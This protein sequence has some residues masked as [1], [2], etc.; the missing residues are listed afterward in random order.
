[1]ILTKIQY[2][3]KNKA[4]LETDEGYSV[5][6]EQATVLEYSLHEGDELTEDELTVIIRHDMEERAKALALNY[7]SY[8]LRSEKEVSDYLRGKDFDSEI[9]SA[10]IVR[11]RELGYLND[12]EFAEAFVKDRLKLSKHGKS[13]IAFELKLKGIDPL[14]IQ[15]ALRGIGSSELRNAVQLIRKKA[16]DL[17]DFKEQRRITGMLARK[18]YSY[19]MISRAISLAETEPDDE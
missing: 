19:E 11:F 1:M 2:E 14:I 17:S 4:V 5:I 3:K 18:G 9:C 6:L 10:V 15:E 13:R 12:A 8:R 16:G 7:I